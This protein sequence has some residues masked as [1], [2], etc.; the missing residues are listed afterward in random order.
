MKSNGKGKKMMLNVPKLAGQLIVMTAFV[1]VATLASYGQSIV[2]G[3]VEVTGHLGIISGIGS[4]GSFGGSIGA[5][6]TDRL[7]LSGDL[8]Y[9]PFGGGSVRILGSTTTTSSKA[10]NL[11]GNL[12]YQFKPLHASVPY[13]GAGL[14]FLHSSF[15]ASSSG[16]VV[17][18]GGSTD[19]YFNVG[20]GLRYYVRDRWGFRPE[21]MIFAG[22]NT[23]VRFAGGIFYQFGE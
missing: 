13:A 1:V 4:H 17:A 3:N 22:S 20:G 12:Q 18:Q 15:D 14:G 11:N 23:Y 19:L 5:P 21:F 10:F 8:S 6:V 16:S 9:I 2:P 7:I